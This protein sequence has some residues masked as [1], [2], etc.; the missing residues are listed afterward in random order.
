MKRFLFVVLAILFTVTLFSPLHAQGGDGEACPAVCTS[1]WE[2]QDH[3][4]VWES[5]AVSHWQSCSGCGAKAAEAAHIPG[6][7]ATADSPQVCTVCGYELAPAL[8]SEPTEPAGS[9]AD[10]APGGADKDARDIPLGWILFVSVIVAA[11]GLTI[12]AVK[13]IKF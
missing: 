1:E 4:V 11:A 5:D 13:K 6:E 8:G 12:V 7:Q 3:G 10:T 9:T 2:A